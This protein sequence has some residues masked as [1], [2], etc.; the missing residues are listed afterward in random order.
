LIKRFSSVDGVAAVSISISSLA[1]ESLSQSSS[2][3]LN[4]SALIE[5]N[6]QLNVQANVRD[7]LMTFTTNLII[8]TADS[9]KLQSSTLSQLTQ[10]TNQLT[11]TTAVRINEIFCD[12]FYLN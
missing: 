12:I 9:I 3:L 7:Y 1:V 11:R 5:F 10:A 2:A 4:Q 6:K 8:T